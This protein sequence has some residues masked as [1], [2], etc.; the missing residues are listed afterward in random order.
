MP[1]NMLDKILEDI[2]DK[3]SENISNKMLEYFPIIKYINIMVEIIRN[4]IYFIYIY[5]YINIYIY[6]C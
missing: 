5:I 1:E 4:K 6:I 3:I 2:L